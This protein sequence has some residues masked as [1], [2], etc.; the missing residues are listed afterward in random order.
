M[1]ERD[2]RERLFVADMAGKLRLG[3]IRRR[4]FLHAVTR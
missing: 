1:N 4:A 3:R 2:G